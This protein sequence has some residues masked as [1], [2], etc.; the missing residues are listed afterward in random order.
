MLVY[1]NS[2]AEGILH[3]VHV[4]WCILVKSVLHV[5]EPIL[6]IPSIFIVSAHDHLADRLLQ[7]VRMEL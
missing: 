5:R 6:A 4:R 1:L 3:A 2:E 7:G